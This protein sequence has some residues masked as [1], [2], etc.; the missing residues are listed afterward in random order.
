MHLRESGGWHDVVMS[1]IMG[2]GI[3]RWR[4][5]CTYSGSPID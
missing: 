5:R 4:W 3:G 2:G 1:S